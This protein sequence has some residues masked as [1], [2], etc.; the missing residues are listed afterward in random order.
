MAVQEARMRISGM[1]C[2]HCKAAVEK[3][4][5]GVPG[6]LQADVLLEEGVAVVAFDPGRVNVERLK[7]QVE[8]AGYT[9]T[10]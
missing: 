7:K 2:G 8:D 4:L 5:T 6:V 10:T 3:A 1:S 9:V